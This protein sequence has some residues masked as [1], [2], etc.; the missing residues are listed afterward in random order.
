MI[1]AGVRGLIDWRPSMMVAISPTWFDCGW[2]SLNYMLLL[3]LTSSLLL[4]RQDPLV[5][6]STLH[7]EVPLP[8]SSLFCS[9]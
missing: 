9:W 5:N 3:H 7:P 1:I 4:F 6:I 8:A 2:F